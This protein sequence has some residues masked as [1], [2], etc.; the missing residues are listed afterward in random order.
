MRRVPEGRQLLV[1][2]GVEGQRDTSGPRISLQPTPRVVFTGIFLAGT[3]NFVPGFSAMVT[4]GV[5]PRLRVSDP[6]PDGLLPRAF[7]P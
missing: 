6:F 2:A 7:A 3:S 1:F 4:Y 5:T